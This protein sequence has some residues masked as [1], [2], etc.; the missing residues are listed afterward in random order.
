MKE[1]K[2]QWDLDM[3]MTVL[4]HQTVDSETWAEAVEWLMLY[5][6]PHVQDML[7]Q[8]S[9]IATSQ[10]FPELKPSG[11]NP[12]GTPLYDIEALAKA[13][14]ISTDEVYE[15]LRTKE[16]LQQTRHLF[17]DGDAMKIH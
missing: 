10:Y 6:P 15:K 2:K 11:Y 9:H 13:L 4:A 7:N 5:G 14:N 16:Q 3:A 1:F 17:G 8:A 12:D